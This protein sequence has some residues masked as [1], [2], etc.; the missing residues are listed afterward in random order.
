MISELS[1]V[2]NSVLKCMLS[3][4]ATERSSSRTSVLEEIH[5]VLHQV[6]SEYDTAQ[7]YVRAE[8]LLL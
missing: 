6:S 8:T 1:Y 2:V 3:K 5:M 4:P 7:Y